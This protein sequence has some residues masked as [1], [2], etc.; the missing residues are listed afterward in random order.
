[1]GTIKF[2]RLKPQAPVEIIVGFSAV[3]RSIWLI[4]AL[5]LERHTRLTTDSVAFDATLYF[6]FLLSGVVLIVGALKNNTFLRLTGLFSI[7]GQTIYI[8]LVTA[9]SGPVILPS[10]LGNILLI[11]ITLALL[12]FNGKEGAE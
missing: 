10:S 12:F 3:A 9:F 4:S 6:V 8:V 11:V 2:S 1:M 5:V 7:L